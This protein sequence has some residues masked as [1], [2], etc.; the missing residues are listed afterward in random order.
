MSCIQKITLNKI[1]RTSFAKKG[2][3]NRKAFLEFISKT[4]RISEIDRV[5]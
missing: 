5:N 3:L 1:K 2:I 4:Y